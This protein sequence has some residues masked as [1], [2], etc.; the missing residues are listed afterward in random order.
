MTTSL[1]PGQ[2]MTI[3]VRV[4][5]LEQVRQLCCGVRYVT[6]RLRTP[7]LDAAVRICA[8]YATG[9]DELVAFFGELADGW[10]G[11]Q[12]E[13]TYESLE[14]DLRFTAVHDGHVRLSICL[15][16]TSTPSGWSASAVIQLGPGE[17]LIQAAADLA[18]LL[19]ALAL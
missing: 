19:W 2:R 7:G 6:V 1:L 3:N 11:L 15:Q 13:R 10:R 8:R 5:R 12:G 14:H 18:A 4:A 17:E 9:F 16:Q